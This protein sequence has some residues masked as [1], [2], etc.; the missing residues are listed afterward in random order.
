MQENYL[1]IG[2]GILE[3]GDT[4]KIANSA[5]TYFYTIKQLYTVW[6]EQLATISRGTASSP[7]TQ[8]LRCTRL[9]K[10]YPHYEPKA[11]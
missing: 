1:D 5:D 4:V 11:N 2:N 3:L 10:Q 6:G 9:L 7:N 8:T